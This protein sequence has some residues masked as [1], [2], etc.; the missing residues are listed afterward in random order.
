MAEGPEVASGEAPESSGGPQRGASVRAIADRAWT[1]YTGDLSGE[2]MLWVLLAV[3]CTSGPADNADGSGT[4]TTETPFVPLTAGSFN[5][6]SGGSLISEVGDATA[7]TPR[8]SLW[9]FSEVKDEEW[10][11][12]LTAAAG[13][14]YKYEMGTTGGGDKLVIAWDP[15]RLDLQGFEELKEMNVGGTVRATLVGTFVDS[16]TDVELK[17]AVNHLWRSDNDKRHEQAEIFREWGAQQDV[18]VIAM[19][20]YN[21]DWQV[22]GGGH[23]EGYDIMTDDD[24]WVWIRPD[25]II[26]TQCNEAYDSVLD[27]AFASELAQDW[28]STSVILFPELTYCDSGSAKRSDHRPIQA[29][30]E[31]PL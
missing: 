18:P 1:G 4:E 3:A 30:F 17:F 8:A 29:T 16:E 19:G 12:E 24:V 31:I 2:S 25:E 27:F 10:A 14:G 6:E 9:G 20:D 23:D 28:E 7:D 5:V 26:R 15:D 22:D 13:S 11:Q 21:F